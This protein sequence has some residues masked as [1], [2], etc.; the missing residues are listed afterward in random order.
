MEFPRLTEQQLRANDAEFNNLIGNVRRMNTGLADLLMQNRS[1]LE[2]HIKSIES[3]VEIIEQ[4]HI[5]KLKLS[6]RRA[7]QWQKT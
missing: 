3:E 6:D 2:S 7:N 4:F 1:K 5:A